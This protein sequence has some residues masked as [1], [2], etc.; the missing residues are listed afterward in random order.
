MEPEGVTLLSALWKAG[1][2]T[3]LAHLLRAFGEG[4][5]FLGGDVASTQVLYI[6]EESQGRW[7]KRRDALGLGDWIR[8]R[9]QPFTYK[10]NFAAWFA[11][12]E[13]LNAEVVR[14]G[15]GLVVFDTLDKLWPVLKE[16]DA[17]EVASALMPLRA[18]A[19]A[20][21]LNHHLGKSDGKEGMA[22]RGSGA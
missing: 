21:L 13:D 17:G 4:G 9:C 1:K 11:F 19:A 6:S 22:S 18:L 2:T 7:A 15:V 10:P 12:L 8:F 3:L 16:N 5:V 14:D 20:S